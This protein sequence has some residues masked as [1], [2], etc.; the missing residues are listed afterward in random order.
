MT[1]NAPQAVQVQWNEFLLCLYKKQAS[2][3]F[4]SLTTHIISTYETS[5][6]SLC[7]LL[8]ASFLS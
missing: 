1:I 5:L 3:I 8:L 6:F 2:F 4:S 7:V